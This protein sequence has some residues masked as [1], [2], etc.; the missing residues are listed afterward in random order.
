MFFKPYN[1]LETFA[2]YEISEDT[3]ESEEESEITKNLTTDFKNQ[4]LTQNSFNPESDQI[5][6]ELIE[7]PTPEN[8]SSKIKKKLTNILEEIG[9]LNLLKHKNHLFMKNGT[10]LMIKLASVVPYSQ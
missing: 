3:E 10:L 6:F 1:P 2:D 7:I 4:S 8:I 5:Y 9:H